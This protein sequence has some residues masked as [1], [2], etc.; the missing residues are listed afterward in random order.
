MLGQI[1]VEGEFGG[2]SFDECSILNKYEHIKGG[3]SWDYFRIKMGEG[4]F[5]YWKE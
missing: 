2:S 4:E 3:F 5:L 1:A